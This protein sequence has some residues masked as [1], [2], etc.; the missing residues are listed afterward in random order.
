MSVC[1]GIVLLIHWWTD[2]S[3]HEIRRRV[4]AFVMVAFVLLYAALM[5]PWEDPSIGCYRSSNLEPFCNFEGYVD[6]A[7]FGI[8]HLYGETDP[9]GIVSTLTA[10]FTTYVGY[11][12]GLLLLK[13]KKHLD[14]LIKYWLLAAFLFLLAIYPCSLVMPPNKKIYSLT[15]LFAVLSTSAT[16]LT[17][18]LIVIDYVPQAV[19][20]H[21]RAVHIITRPF[22]WLGMNPLAV[23]LLLQ[24]L[25]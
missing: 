6:R 7:V 24:I 13:H 3:T 4:A 14:T 16:I 18:L 21:S 2:Y 15:F 17:L 11:C 12:F 10:S 22:T 8:D 19:R 9:E 5:L 25:S 20:K 1:Y 23:F